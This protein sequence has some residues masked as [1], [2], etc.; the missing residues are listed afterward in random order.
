[1]TVL[2]DPK[3]RSSSLSSLSLSCEVK[4]EVKPEVEPEEWKEIGHSLTQKI[5]N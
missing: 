4:P 1:L 3:S 5:E 2:C